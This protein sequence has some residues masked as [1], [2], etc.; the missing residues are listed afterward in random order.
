M[1]FKSF[2]KVGIGRLNEQ[3]GSMLLLPVNMLHG[4]LCSDANVAAK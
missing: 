1:Y 3:V 4:I 2:Y